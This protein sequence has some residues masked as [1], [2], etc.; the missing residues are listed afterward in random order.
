MSERRRRGADRPLIVRPSP[1]A[2]TR[3]QWLASLSLLAGASGCDTKDPRAGF[4]GSMERW[5]ER[6]QRWLLKPGRLAKPPADDQTTPDD[7]FPSY[8]IAD[9]VPLA[10]AG[11]A[12]RVGGLVARPGVFSLDDL[13]RMTRTDV[14]VRHYCVEGWSAVASWHGV[15]LRDL[16]ER[17]GADPRAAYVEVRSF[18][19]GYWSSWDRESALHPQTILAYGMNGRELRPDH[20]A[21]LRLYAAVKLGYKMVKYLTEVNFRDAKTGGYWEDQGYE[22]FAGV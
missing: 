1:L 6:F 5:N 13:Q 14:R 9:E 20:G 8:H 22:W 17:V 10:P 2:L 18:D 16:A 3:R 7:D 15:A 11:W 21:P 4:L 12:L 19:E